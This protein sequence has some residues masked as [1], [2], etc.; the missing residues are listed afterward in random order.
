MMSKVTEF[1]GAFSKD[2]AMQERAN[3][4]ISTGGAGEKIKAEAII[5]FA[6][7]EGYL[8][9]EEELNG[10]I[11]SK[12]LSDDDLKAVAGGKM[13]KHKPGQLYSEAHD[14]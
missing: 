14:C 1:Y 2:E 7:K 13:K 12:E 5:A 11:N 10:F 9:T 6:K 4:L 8:F 3:A